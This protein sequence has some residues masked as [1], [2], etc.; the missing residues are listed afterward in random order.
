[1]HNKHICLKEETLCCTKDC[2]WSSSIVLNLS[3]LTNTDMSGHFTSMWK[4]LLNVVLDVL[5]GLANFD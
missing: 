3:L 1:M 4:L 2:E 5:K